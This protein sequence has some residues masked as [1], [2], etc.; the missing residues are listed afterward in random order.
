MHVLDR[1]IHINNALI[2]SLARNASNAYS[3]LQ[4][5]ELL[6]E[7]ANLC[8][9][10]LTTAES[11]INSVERNVDRLLNHKVP[12]DFLSMPDLYSHLGSINQSLAV[13]GVSLIP[14]S[15]P[16]TISLSTSFVVQNGIVHIFIHF[17]V[18]S[19]PLLNV[20][21]YIST[22]FVH[23]DTGISAS[24][25]TPS[26]HI[27]AIS[28]HGFVELT[29]FGR[30]VKIT[31]D[32][33]RCPSFQV[34][35]TDWHN[36]C[37]VSLFLQ[38]TS[39]ITKACPSTPFTLPF[40]AVSLSHT[41]FFFYSSAPSVGKVECGLHNS[42]LPIPAGKSVVTVPEH[43]SLEA[44][45]IRLYPDIEADTKDLIQLSIDPSFPSSLYLRDV[46]ETDL[47]QFNA[48][49]YGNIVEVPTLSD[50]P[51]SINDHL[52]L[53][54]I[55][56]AAVCVTLLAGCVAYWVCRQKPKQGTTVTVTT[57]A[58]PARRDSQE[59]RPR[60]RR[61]SELEAWV[62]QPPEFPMTDIPR[63]H[64]ANPLVTGTRPKIGPPRPP[65]PDVKVVYK[66]ID[67]NDESDKAIEI[68][69][70]LL[71]P[72]PSISCLSL[73]DTKSDIVNEKTIDVR[74]DVRAKEI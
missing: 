26:N 38:N 55:I 5:E 22:P 21:E 68:T 6:L 27:L 64:V 16:D 1:D 67:P 46:D 66:N 20:F 42:M 32:I 7:Q 9:I 24:L 12:H 40:Y 73:T 71:H 58:S 54:S 3:Q 17:P 48:S 56:T 44:G 13:H 72:E 34:L 52:T 63:S 57:G 39:Q 69:K 8:S 60:R 15:Y 29:D 59:S 51:L 36:S 25:L 19:N 53:G 43:C 35:R 61:N 50:L 28:D 74:S 70:P 10:H 30:C 11:Y 41:Q 49:L 45:N 37:L 62:T 18:T 33:S 2:S 47:I 4:I 23:Y 14:L 65:K 31:T